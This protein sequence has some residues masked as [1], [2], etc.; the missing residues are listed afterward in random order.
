MVFLSLPL[1]KPSHP[2]PSSGD[3]SKSIVIVS[4]VVLY[5]LTLTRLSHLPVKKSSSKAKVKKESLPIKRRPLIAESD[6]EDDFPPVHDTYTVTHPTSWYSSFVCY[7]IQPPKKQPSPT[8][9]SPVTKSV[10]ST[11]NIPRVKQE[12]P[13]T[14]QKAHVTNS[15]KGKK[16][17]AVSISVDKPMATSCAAVAESVKKEPPI[18]PSTPAPQKT[19]VKRERKEGGTGKARGFSV[20]LFKLTMILLCN[21]IKPTAE[22]KSLRFS[23]EESGWHKA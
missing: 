20:V 19:P 5:G 6:S 3:I 23:K 14:P 1:Q 8:K 10:S 17:K 9:A 11:N 22:A 21:H 4:T 16:E 7:L 12:P 18:T 2:S 15:A 13:S